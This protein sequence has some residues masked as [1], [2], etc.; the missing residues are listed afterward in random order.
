MFEVSRACL[1]VTPQF[2]WV[3]RPSWPF[4][5]ATCRRVKGTNP[6][7]PFSWSVPRP[8]VGL[9]R[10]ST[11]QGRVPP[12]VQLHRYG[13][14]TVILNVLSTGMSRSNGVHAG[15]QWRE[16]YVV[17]VGHA[18]ARAAARHPQD[19]RIRRGE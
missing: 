5:A 2:V 4:S 15:G 3:E 17:A 14:P 19:V 7:S 16:H 9:V 8:A 18:G 1:P 13:L 10:D 6:R 12:R 11:G